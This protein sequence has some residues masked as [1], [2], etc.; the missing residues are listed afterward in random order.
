M[1][2]GCITV[3]IKYGTE[4]PLKTAREVL[5]YLEAGCGWVIASH[6]DVF[7]ERDD[8]QE[9]LERLNSGQQIEEFAGV[10]HG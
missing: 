2:D 1:K 5:E 9:K 8:A 3:K 7:A 10:N 4:Q 6:A